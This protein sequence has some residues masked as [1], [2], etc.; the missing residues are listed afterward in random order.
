MYKAARIAF[1]NAV[2]EKLVD[3]FFCMR[4]QSQANNDR[5]VEM[6]RSKMS[7][8]CSYTAKGTKQKKRVFEKCDLDVH[9]VRFFFKEW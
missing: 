8:P 5:L 9:T 1:F 7:A 3:D 4:A 2:E 6:K